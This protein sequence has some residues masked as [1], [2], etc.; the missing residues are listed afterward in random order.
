[1][2]RLEFPR[3]ER[4]RRFCCCGWDDDEEDAV[5]ESVVEESQEAASLATWL[6]FSS[7]FLAAL[8]ALVV[9]ALVGPRRVVAV[10]GARARR[11]EPLLSR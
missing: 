4:R 8:A 2:A 5:Q 7:T 1:M 10:L 3:E 6:R 11:E 9:T